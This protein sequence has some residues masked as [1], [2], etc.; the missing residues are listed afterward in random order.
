MHSSATDS[1]GEQAMSAGLAVAW[2]HAGLPAPPPQPCNWTMERRADHCC[3]RKRRSTGWHACW[4]TEDH[5][6]YRQCCAIPDELLEEAPA[7]ATLA[8]DPSPWCGPICGDPAGEEKRPWEMLR[9]HLMSV[10]AFRPRPEAQL[11]EV[12]GEAMRGMLQWASIE[13][14]SSSC[15]VGSM[16]LELLRVADARAD[17]GPLLRAA[18]SLA[19]DGKVLREAFC[20]GWPVFRLLSLAATNMSRAGADRDQVAELR[21]RYFDRHLLLGKVSREFA[22]DPGAVLHT[23]LLACSASARKEPCLS[24]SRPALEAVHESQGRGV[25]GVGTCPPGAIA[26]W[27]DRMEP[28]PAFPLCVRAAGN[29]VDGELK[30][31][32]RWSACLQL[33]RLLSAGGL[34]HPGCRVLDIGANIGACTVMLAKIGY[35]VT[36]FEPLPRNAELLEASLELNGLLRR[37]AGPEGQEEETHG[38]SATLLR[39]ALGQKDSL[40]YVL[41]GRN[42]AGMSVVLHKEPGEECNA[43]MFLCHRAVPTP[44]ARLDDLVRPED[45]PV[46]LAKMDVEG[47][48]LQV[49]RGAL[50]LL[51]ARTIKAFHLEWWPPHLDAMGEEPA[52][53]LWLLHSLRYEIFAPAWWFHPNKSKADQSWAMVVPEQFPFLLQHWGDIVARAAPW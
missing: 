19:S 11:L 16:I 25:L 26:A 36:A 35:S 10:L 31:H 27:L 47:L 33:A 24:A 23:M 28:A 34:G 37:A 22:A 30:M 41:E 21:Q 52:D 18:W 15:Q 9:Y 8:A 51:Q 4:F 20:S 29:T 14:M 48:E 50:R 7:P 1:I 2:P 6:S 42:N 43:E 32:G 44:V 38:G 3:T 13:S 17:R 5:F 39:T 12:A 53:L 49:L 40:S 45:G 46:C